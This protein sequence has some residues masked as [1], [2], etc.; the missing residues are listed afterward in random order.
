[1][2]IKSLF[3]CKRESARGS[4]GIRYQRGRRQQEG[5]EPLVAAQPRHHSSHRIDRRIALFIIVR[6]ATPWLYRHH[7][8][9]LRASSDG[10]ILRERVRYLT[11][12]EQRHEVVEVHRAPVDLLLEL[13]HSR[14]RSRYLLSG[15]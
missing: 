6:L 2:I 13:L 5:R 9:V 10:D 1:M 4:G 7:P 8:S 3:T 15:R 11:R 12:S 14:H